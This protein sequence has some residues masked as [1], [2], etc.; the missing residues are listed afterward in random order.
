MENKYYIKDELEIK[1]ELR[2]LSLISKFITDLMEK[3]SIDQRIIYH[4]QM[5]VDEACANIIIHG[6]PE[7]GKIKINYC[8]LQQNKT[9]GQITIKIQ[10]HGMK[11]D[12]DTIPEPDINTTLENRKIGGLG[13]FFI[14]KLMDDIQYS[15]QNGKNE[16]KLVKYL[17]K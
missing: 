15:S 5:A 14:K 12:I 13:V 10:D 3:S 2:N 4:T 1:G 17:K 8:L 6:N 9:P 16:L 7:M 11:L